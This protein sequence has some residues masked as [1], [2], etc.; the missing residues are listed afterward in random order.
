MTE[1]TMVPIIHAI[2][3]AF[4]FGAQAVVAS[5]S[6]KYVDPQ[7]SSMIAIGTCVV[8]FWLLAPF[9]MNADYFRNPGMLVFMANGLIHPLFSMYLVFEANKRMGAT[10]SSTISSTTPLFAAACAALMLGEKP[11]IS[12]L[13]GTLG[14]ILGVMILSWKRSGPTNWALAALF[15]PIG[16][17]IV[18]GMN[19]TI[20]KFGLEMLPSPFYASIVSFTISFAGSV[21]IYRLRVGALPLKLPARG[22]RWSALAGL[23]IGIGVLFMYSALNTG[24]VIVVSPIISTSP[25]FAFLLSLLLR[26]EVLSKRL[27][28]GVIFVVGGVTWISLQ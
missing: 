22:L 9:K 19:Q 5:R 18:R 2:I 3:A 15:F 26:Q 14:T 6:F 12:L 16:T 24:L 13:M 4:F 10:V 17:A 11:S 21:L 28:L 23:F 25:L 8:F 1:V 27:L 20:G 7:T